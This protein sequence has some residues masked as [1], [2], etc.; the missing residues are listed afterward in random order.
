M[1]LQRR[2]IALGSALH[3]HFNG[4]ALDSHSASKRQVAAEATARP[5][6]RGEISPRLSR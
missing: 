4:G 3:R 1:T 2:V 5:G 6:D